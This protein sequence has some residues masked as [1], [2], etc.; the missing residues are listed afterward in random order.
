V[1]FVHGLKRLAELIDGVLANVVH[2]VIGNG[3]VLSTK[4]IEGMAELL[5]QCYQACRPDDNRRCIAVV[6]TDCA[7]VLINLLKK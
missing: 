6:M 2:E 5:R 1:A 3:V 7:R 4:Q